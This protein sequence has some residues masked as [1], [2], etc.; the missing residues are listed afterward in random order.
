MYEWEPSLPIEHASYDLH[1]CKVYNMIEL[2]QACHDLKESVQ[3]KLDVSLE[4]F[5]AN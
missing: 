2:I 4:S 1:D 3:S 5:Y